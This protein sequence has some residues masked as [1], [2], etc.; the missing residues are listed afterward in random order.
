MKV[1]LTLTRSE[2]AGLVELVGAC[3]GELRGE[4]LEEVQYREGLRG[5][6]LKLAGRAGAVKG[7]N[8]LMLGELETLALWATAGEATARTS[9]LGWAVW[10][11]IAE[12]TDRQKSAAEALRRGNGIL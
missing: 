2:Y 10:L 3:Y 11:K 7:K 6:A 1:R 9:P 12:E 8:R 5:L 4:S